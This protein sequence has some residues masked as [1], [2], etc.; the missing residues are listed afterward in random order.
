MLVKNKNK[1]E[2][3]KSKGKGMICRTGV[4]S[5]RESRIKMIL[6]VIFFF[7]RMTSLIS[8]SF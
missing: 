2:T 7:A 4:A 1:N 8:T 5:D 6:P 3:G